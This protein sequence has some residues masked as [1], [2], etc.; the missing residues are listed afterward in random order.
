MRPLAKRIRRSGPP[1]ADIT[2]MTDPDNP[3]PDHAHAVRA[4]RENTAGLGLARRAHLAS[5]TASAPVAE[6]F[7][8]YAYREKPPQDRACFCEE[9]ES[10]FG[11]L[12]VHTEIDAR[13]GRR[14]GIRVSAARA[15]CAGELWGALA[16]W[17]PE[18]M[19]DDADVRAAFP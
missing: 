14:L 10:E 17:L 2:L 19:F 16:N 13:V 1:D 9:V 12:G 18:G 7:L 4:G 3:M 15:G 5:Y 8:P 11:N 6:L